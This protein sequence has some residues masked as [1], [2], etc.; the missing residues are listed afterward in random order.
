MA[1]ALPARLEYEF[2]TTVL[3]E[4]PVCRRQAT[5]HGDTTLGRGLRRLTCLS[6]G[7][8]RMPRLPWS[9]NL[10]FATGGLPLWLETDTRHGRLY[11]VN[12]EHLDYIEQY[13]RAALRKVDYSGVTFRNQ[14]LTSRLPAWVKAAKNRTEVLKAIEK[15]RRR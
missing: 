6:C 11:A 12:Y 9:G 3:V 7:H 1:A 13:V 8:S 2:L 4:C 10:C 15:M 5:I 14:S